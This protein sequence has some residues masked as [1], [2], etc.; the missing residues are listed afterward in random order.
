MIEANANCRHGWPAEVTLDVGALHGIAHSAAVIY[1]GGVSPERPALV[2]DEQ[3]RQPILGD[4]ERFGRE[5]ADRRLRLS[6]RSHA[7]DF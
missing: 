2:S 6:S 1:A 4:P 7:G 3:M 5:V